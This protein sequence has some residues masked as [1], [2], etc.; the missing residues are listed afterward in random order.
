MRYFA[1]LLKPPG[2]LLAVGALV[3]AGVFIVA[4]FFASPFLTANQP[5]YEF[6]PPVMLVAALSLLLPATRGFGVGLFASLLIA[7]VAGPFD[8]WMWW[9]PLGDM[10][11]HATRPMHD[12]RTARDSTVA[13]LGTAVSA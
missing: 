2:W 13:C 8:R 5:H 6:F 3:G 9:R 7:T 10:A 11:R 12:Q 4:S 1:W